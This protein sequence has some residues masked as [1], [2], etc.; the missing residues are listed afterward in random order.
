M[1]KFVCQVLPDSTG[2]AIIKD[3]DVTV[4]YVQ[5]PVGAK[6]LVYTIRLIMLCYHFD[7]DVPLFKFVKA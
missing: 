3:T 7:D 5:D 6:N 1:Y 4:A 2:L